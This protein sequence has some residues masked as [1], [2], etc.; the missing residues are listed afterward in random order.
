MFRLTVTYPATDGAT[1]DFDYYR[2]THMPL[3]MARVGAAAVKFEIAR[4]VSSSTGGAAPYMCIGQVY[5]SSLEAFEAA[6][7]EHG[8]ELFAD[9]ANYTNI[10]PIGQLEELVS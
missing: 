8:A 4:G 1:F 6:M 5:L 2:D 7:A 10:A 3:V 9:V